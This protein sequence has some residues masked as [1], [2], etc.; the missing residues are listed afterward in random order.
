M[1]FLKGVL[2]YIAP[3]PSAIYKAA[4]G[5]SAE[6]EED[7]RELKSRWDDLFSWGIKKKAPDT[8]YQWESWEA[9]SEQ[10]EDGE[11]DTDGLVAQTADLEVAER[12]AEEEGYDREGK[13]QVVVDDAG[14][15]VKKAAEVF[16]EEADRLQEKALPPGKPP[17]LPTWIPW[18]AYAAAGGAAL[19]YFGGTL[20]SSYVGSTRVSVT[21]GRDPAS[22]PSPLPSPKKKRR[23][24]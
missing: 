21:R 19:L 3:G 12:R 6:A 4:T 17:G 1:G 10:W 13:T 16:V 14:T 15:P 20:L 7:Y 11:A 8:K 2:D 23:K 9:F 18:W 5:P 22:P 24:T